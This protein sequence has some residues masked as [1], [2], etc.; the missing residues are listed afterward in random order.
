[1]TVNEAIN[2]VVTEIPEI[3]RA[4][5]LTY[6]RKVHRWVYQNWII[7]TD[8]VDFNLTANVGTLTLA[9]NVKR[10]RTVNYYSQAG[11][12]GTP[13]ET[14]ST[15]DWDI[16][17]PNWRTRKASI[18]M[19][20]A[21]EEGKII[22]NPAPATTTSGGYPK[23][24]ASVAVATELAEGDTLPWNISPDLYTEGVKYWYARNSCKDD[25]E[26]SVAM[27]REQVDILNASF[28][29]ISHHYRPQVTPDLDFEQAI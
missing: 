10:V 12:E 24:T 9:D 23:I 8:V 11:N 17:T 14:E 21:V 19:A 27:F 29:K 20:F 25:I 5:A 15:A 18:P 1:M 7:K 3:G 16:E 2:E 26:L 13:L 4:K 6:L 28:P 22:L